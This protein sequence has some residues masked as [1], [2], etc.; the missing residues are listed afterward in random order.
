[1]RLF[2]LCL[3][4]SAMLTACH[5]SRRT[6]ASS[7]VSLDS[8]AVSSKR[9]VGVDW[10]EFF[11]RLSV[12]FDSLSVCIEPVDS[13]A[14]R[15]HL[16]AAKASADYNAHTAS[17]TASHTVAS[18]SSFRHIDASLRSDTLSQTTGVTK[19][20]DFTWIVVGIAAILICL[21]VW[22]NCVKD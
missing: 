4:L 10:S 7:D 20:T 18:D 13:P 12:S 16:R 21:L 19:P 2:S 17:A 22:R 1:M 14:Y 5:S 6:V 8:V 9:T 11:S 3:I 15:L